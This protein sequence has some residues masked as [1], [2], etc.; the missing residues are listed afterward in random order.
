MA[1]DVVLEVRCPEGIYDLLR[2]EG[3]DTVLLSRE[4]RESL[5]FRLYAEHRLSI[6]KAAEL[7]ELPIVRFMDL[8]RTVGL[9]VAE[10]GEEEYEEDLKIIRSRRRS[11]VAAL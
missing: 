8:L 9:P 5:A 1:T 10:Y 11:V 7:A 2:A 3:A 4:A 6:G